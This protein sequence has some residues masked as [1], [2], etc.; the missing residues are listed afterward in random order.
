[1]PAHTPSGSAPTMR[2]LKPR[3]QSARQRN[4]QSEELNSY[5]Q[6]RCRERIEGLVRLGGFLAAVVPTVLG[7]GALLGSPRVGVQ[8]ALGLACNSGGWLPGFRLVR[9]VQAAR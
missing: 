7:L 6:N 1:M 3:S 4:E 5:L 8:P 2:S 9:A